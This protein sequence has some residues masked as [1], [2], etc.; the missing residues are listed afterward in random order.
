M[1]LFTYFLNG[2]ALTRCAKLNNAV[3]GYYYIIK[4]YLQFELL[5]IPLPLDA[6]HTLLTPSGK[7]TLTPGLIRR[8]M[9]HFSAPLDVAVASHPRRLR[10]LASSAVGNAETLQSTEKETMD[11]R[12]HQVARMQPERHLQPEMLTWM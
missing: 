8:I 12:I 4:F 7:E 2:S 1:A 11:E 5:K 10:A 9:H 6:L 3:L